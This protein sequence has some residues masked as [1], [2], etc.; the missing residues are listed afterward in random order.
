META[1]H[2][3]DAQS[4]RV[5]DAD[6]KGLGQQETCETD[7]TADLR[8]FDLTGTP[9]NDYQPA[10]FD[11]APVVVI[12]RSDQE[13][14]LD[15]T[16]LFDEAAIPLTDATRLLERLAARIEMPALHLL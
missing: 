1:T 15:I 4:I 6:R 5:L 12:T 13:D 16:L 2:G 8:V 7:R 10:N 11:G 14:R 9:L 3:E